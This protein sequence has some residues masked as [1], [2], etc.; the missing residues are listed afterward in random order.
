[1]P[2]FKSRPDLNWFLDANAALYPLDRDGA[3]NLVKAGTR[4]EYAAAI[5]EITGTGPGK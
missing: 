5:Q 3:Q 4:M 2:V 1:L